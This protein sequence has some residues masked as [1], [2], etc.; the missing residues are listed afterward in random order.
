M[1]CNFH[2][3]N[4]TLSNYGSEI[5]GGGIFTFLICTYQFN[6]ISN[7]FINEWKRH[8]EFNRRPGNLK[9][10]FEVNGFFR[11]PWVVRVWGYP[12]IFIVLVFVFSLMFENAC[13]PLPKQNEKTRLRSADFFEEKTWVVRVWG[14]PWILLVSMLGFW[15]MFTKCASALPP[16]IWQPTLKTSG[17]LLKALGCMRVGLPLDIYSVGVCVCLMGAST[18]QDL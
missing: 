7:I 17:F 1:C 4:E 8:H 6:S 2:S 10:M 11:K 12:W 5:H 13:P 14:Y 15:F 3:P 18:R 9:N 16:T